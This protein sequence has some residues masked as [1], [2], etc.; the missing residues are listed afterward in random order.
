[1]V[2]RIV[3]F[4]DTTGPIKSVDDVEIFSTMDEFGRIEID[5]TLVVEEN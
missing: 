3:T 1:M 2:D 4:D 5:V